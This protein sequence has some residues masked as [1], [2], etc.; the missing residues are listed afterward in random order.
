MIK[1]AM[2]ALHRELARRRLR[3]RMILQV[4]DELVFEAAAEEVEEVQQ[5]ARQA[6]QS[7]LELRV[8]VV[9]DVCIG[10]NWL[11]AH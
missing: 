8:P 9:V 1:K 3:S 6:M 4:H 11:E 10:P 7:A 2:V 5:L